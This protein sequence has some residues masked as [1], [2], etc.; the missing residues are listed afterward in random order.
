MEFSEKKIED[1]IINSI[2]SGNIIKLHVRGLYGLTN[3]DKFFRQLDLGDYGR[4]DLV[5]LKYNR[6]RQEVGCV[7]SFDVCVIEIKKGEINYNS[8]IQAIRYCKG[9]SVM[10]DKIKMTAN[11]EIILIGTS[12]CTSDFIYLPD[13]VE[14]LKIYTV[15]LDLEKGITFKN[16]YGYEQSNAKNIKIPT[17]IYI[18]VQEYI[19]S[20]IKDYVN[21]IQEPF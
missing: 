9:I 18:D 17:E 11:F 4:L 20:Q 2:H 3:Y 14:N 21:S 19:Y 7:K 12:V 10:L 8:Y 16:E 1:L 6:Y 15:N 13:F 5:G